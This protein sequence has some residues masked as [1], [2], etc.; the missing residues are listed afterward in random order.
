MENKE[1][2]DMS[3]GSGY[4]LWK[5]YIILDA[6]KEIEDNDVVFYIDAG[7]E[8]INI[9]IINKLKNHMIDLDYIVT[10]FSGKRYSQKIT[11]KRDCF[12]LMNCDEEKYH[13]ALQI[14]AGTL[15][16]KKT[17]FVEDFLNEWLFYCKNKNILTDIPNIHGENL[18]GFM[19]HRHDQSIISNLIIK[20][21]MKYDNTIFPMSI[22]YNFFMP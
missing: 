2:L 7:D 13:N 4:W 6:M 11:T 22:G 17:K 19:Y 20:Y 12:I 21:N 8:I 16:F 14:E 15:A 18:E 10:D 5:P 3:V 1:I 9:D